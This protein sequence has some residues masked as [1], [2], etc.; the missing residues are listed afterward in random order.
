LNRAGKVTAIARRMNP[1]SDFGGDEYFDQT[2]SVRGSA[3]LNGKYADR[4]SGPQ[5]AF[6][7]PSFE[8]DAAAR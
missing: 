1:R 2:G 7:K 3:A 4:E 6:L 8:R 5:A